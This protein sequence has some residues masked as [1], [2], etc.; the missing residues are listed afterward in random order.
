MVLSVVYSYMLVNQESTGLPPKPADVGSTW[1]FDQV[2]QL[3]KYHINQQ[4]IGMKRK[5]TLIA[6]ERQDKGNLLKNTRFC[7]IRFG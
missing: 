4:N 3:S 1:Y 2:I 5:T 7:Q 6:S